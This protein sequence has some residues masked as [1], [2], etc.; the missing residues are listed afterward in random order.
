MTMHTE[1]AIKKQRSDLA[2]INE[3]HKILTERWW[4]GGRWGG[5]L[6]RTPLHT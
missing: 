3:I 2:V 5:V 6:T 1:A 4:G